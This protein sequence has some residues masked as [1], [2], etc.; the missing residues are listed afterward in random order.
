M[1][2]FELALQ[3]IDKLK[4]ELAAEKENHHRLGAWADCPHCTRFFS[5]DMACAYDHA[6]PDETIRRLRGFLTAAGI[7][8]ICGGKAHDLAVACDQ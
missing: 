1:I 8:T 5:S 7:C 4:A 2:A 6:E 3:E